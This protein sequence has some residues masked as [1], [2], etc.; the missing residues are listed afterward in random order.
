MELILPTRELNGYNRNWRSNL[1]PDRLETSKNEN[2]FQEP[3]ENRSTAEPKERAVGRGHL[4]TERT[5]TAVPPAGYKKAEQTTTTV[6][7]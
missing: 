3:G 4:A 7:H 5:S 1:G 6:P 2:N